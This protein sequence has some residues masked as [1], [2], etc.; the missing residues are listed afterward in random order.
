MRSTCS[1]VLG[2]VLG[3]LPFEKVV[4]ISH[5]LH[6]LAHQKQWEIQFS[7]LLAI[8]HLLAVRQ[9]TGTIPS[10][11]IAVYT[12]QSDCCVYPQSDCCVYPP[13]RLLC[14]PSNQIAVYTLQS[15]CCVYPP[16]RLLCIPSNQIAVY[17]LQSDCCVYPPIR[18]LYIPSLYLYRKM[19]RLFCQCSHQPFWWGC[20]REETM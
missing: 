14:I 17:T 13:I 12:L 5:L 18:L 16:I 19:Q 9:V 8:Q 10:N 7:S 3:L 20:R 15:D 11:Q 1:Q 4:K 2:S 6:F